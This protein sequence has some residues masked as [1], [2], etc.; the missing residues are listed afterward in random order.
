MNLVEIKSPATWISHWTYIIVRRDYLV[1][2]ILFSEAGTPNIL[3]HSSIA[4]NI[5]MRFP[6]LAGD[7]SLS[8]DSNLQSKG[9]YS[10]SRPSSLKLS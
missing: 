2:G 1:S 3:R 8:C 4:T 9:W 6:L 10:I 7:S 5:S